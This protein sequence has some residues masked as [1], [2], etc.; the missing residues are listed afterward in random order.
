MTAVDHHGYFAWQSI[1]TVEDACNFIDGESQF[2]ADFRNA[3]IEV[4]WGEWSLATDTC[5]MWL[6]GFNDGAINAVCKPVECPYSY[7]PADE[8]DTSFDRNL[9][10]PQKPY[11]G[12]DQY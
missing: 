9:S 4:W 12:G 6:G 3:G 2:A 11:G 8:F 10:E 1:Q 7:M 5:A